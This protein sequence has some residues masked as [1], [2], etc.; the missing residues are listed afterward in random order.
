[1]L[2]HTVVPLWSTTTTAES[3][4]T[5]ALDVNS[6]RLMCRSPLSKSNPGSAV[7]FQSRSV[8]SVSLLPTDDVLKV[9]VFV[10]GLKPDRLLGLVAAEFVRQSRI[11]HQ[12]EQTRSVPTSV[13]QV[14]PVRST[15]EQDLVP[16]FNLDHHGVTGAQV[17][18]ES[19]LHP[20]AVSSASTVL[21]RSV[22][23]N[24]SPLNSDPPSLRRVW[25]YPNQPFD[26][27]FQVS[28]AVRS[29]SPPTP[30]VVGA[31][32]SHVQDRQFVH[33]PIQ[34]EKIN[35]PRCSSYV[36]GIAARR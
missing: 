23:P 12:H 36:R 4:S 6:C 14:V 15:P 21:V 17:C 32:V 26:E 29:G 35:P 19:S 28:S 20:A 13:K 34:E 33:L 18:F 24:H 27:A 22:R 16:I 30:L 5:S 10:Q 31:V 1:M 9:R 11:L 7:R 2:S 3:I 25:E 8:A